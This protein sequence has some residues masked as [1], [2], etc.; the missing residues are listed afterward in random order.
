MAKE[1]RY[2][3]TTSGDSQCQCSYMIKHKSYLEKV[4]T[5]WIIAPFI[6]DVIYRQ[7]CSIDLEYSCEQGDE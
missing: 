1:G 6:S 2:G 5:I 7:L 4:A 3:K